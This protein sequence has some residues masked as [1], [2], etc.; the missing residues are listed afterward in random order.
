M[1][2]SK[3]ARNLTA[4]P[5]RVS[6]PSTAVAKRLTSRHC[7]PE[8]QLSW[9]NT[10]RPMVSERML[11]NIKRVNGSLGWLVGTNGKTRHGSNSLDHFFWVRPKVTAIDLRG[12]RG[13]ETMSRGSD[14]NHDL[15][16]PSCCAALDDVHRLDFRHGR[17]TATSARMVGV[18][19]EQVFFN[20]ERMAPVIVL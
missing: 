7:S 3:V 18:C 8:N 5:W 10:S 11:T 9:M 19:C 16:T 6:M 17:A 14:N 15:A 4:K 1:I 20:Q 2:S 13:S 12:Q